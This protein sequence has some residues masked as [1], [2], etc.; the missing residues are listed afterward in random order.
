MD[1]SLHEQL[2]RRPENKVPE[3]TSDG[4][5]LRARFEPESKKI[6]YQSEFLCQR[7]MKTEN[8]ADYAED[9]R[10]LANKAFPELQDEARERLALNS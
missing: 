1:L 8:W 4:A 5:V 9:L 7:K 2:G 10:A 6:R 3:G